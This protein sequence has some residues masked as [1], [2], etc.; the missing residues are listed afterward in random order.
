MPTRNTYSFLDASQETSSFGVVSTD[1]TAANFDAQ[2]TSFASLQSAVDNLS[3]A[4]LRTTSRAITPD[5]PN[6]VVPTNPYAQR[7]LKWLVSYT[8]DTSGKEFQIEIPAADLTDNL[9]AG[10]DLADLT[11]TDWAAFIT[12]FEAFARSPD[13]DTETVTVIGARVVGRNI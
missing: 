10:T 11:S 5:V 1:L 7:E 8:G 12:A 9:V 3:I 4:T 6:N 2:A 13:D